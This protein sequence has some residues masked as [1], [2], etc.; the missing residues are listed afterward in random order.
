[1]FSPVSHGK[2]NHEFYRI[3][4]IFIRIMENLKLPVITSNLGC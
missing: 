2:I 1:M 4:M 3:S